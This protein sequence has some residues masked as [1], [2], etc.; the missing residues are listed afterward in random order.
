MLVTSMQPEV[1]ERIEFLRS[2]QVEAPS[3]PGCYVLTAFD[4][5]VLYV[6]LASRS[7]RGRMG[8][9]LEDDFK[10]KGWAGKIPYWFY[11]L[12]LPADRVRPVERGWFNQSI[13]ADGSLPPLNKVHSPV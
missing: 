7:L 10:R 8:N 13:L 5:T 6:G 12:E 9:H 4:L 2:R 1:T 11:Y 3:E